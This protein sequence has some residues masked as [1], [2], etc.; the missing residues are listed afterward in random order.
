M[1]EPRH[2][3]TIQPDEPRAVLSI[4]DRLGAH[5]VVP[6]DAW[7]TLFSTEGYRRLKM[8]EEFMQVPIEDEEFRTFVLSDEMASQA[9][10]LRTSLAEIES[11]DVHAAVAAARV[12]LPAS[13]NVHG[14]IYP[15]IKPKPN[16][17]VFELETDPA[18]FLAVKPD[19]KR[20][21]LANTL[22]HELH[23]WGMGSCSPSTE[24]KKRLADAPQPIQFAIEAL[25]AFGEG[26]AMLAAAGGPNIHP[27]A[28]S[29][30][31]DRERW[32]R[33]VARLGQDLRDLE[34][35]FL[36]ILDARFKTMQELFQ[37]AMRF[38]GETQGPWY[39]V[40][41]KMAQTVELARGRDVLVEC[42]G[43]MRKLLHLYNEATT[44][45]ICWSEDL[46]DRL[47]DVR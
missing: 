5:E 39:T 24:L 21:V 13:A 14:T 28:A 41:W 40:G 16:S 47:D 19:M 2:P 22:V 7:Q 34:S 45:G 44:N 31:E 27:H 12:Y 4:L 25:S 11:L 43:D 8:R 9:G 23:H 30:P 38:M 37:A 26:L 33:D 1:P 15:V 20:A 10:D 18:L 6:G 36:D 29:S 3:I 46:L 35:F 42:M 32:D 17:F